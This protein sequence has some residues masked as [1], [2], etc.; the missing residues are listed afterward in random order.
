MRDDGLDTL[1]AGVRC[2]EVLGELSDYLD[3][4][5]SP[6]R[7]AQLQ[8]HL[9]SCDRCTKF[10]GDVSQALNVLRIGL[11]VPEP[12]SDEVASRLRARVATITGS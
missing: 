2:R 4:D 6:M 9:T 3:G 8:A 5:L 1:V 11:R 10:G 12:L 7:V